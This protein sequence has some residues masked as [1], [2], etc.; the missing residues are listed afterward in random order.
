MPGLV[1]LTSSSSTALSGVVSATRDEYM[2]QIRAGSAANHSGAGGTQN[3]KINAAARD[4]EAVYLAEMIKPMLET[5]E[6]NDVFGGGKGEDVFRGMLADE[7]GKIMARA[8]GIGLA[9]PVREAMIKAQEAAN[10][11]R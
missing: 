6:V 9:S 3:E 1:P 11:Q 10:G 8:G 7:Y 5:V 4:F 2:A